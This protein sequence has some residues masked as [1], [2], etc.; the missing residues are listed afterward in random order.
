MYVIFERKFFWAIWGIYMLFS[1]GIPRVTSAMKKYPDS[2]S[3]KI[4]QGFAALGNIGTG[5]WLTIG[6]VLTV[7]LLIADII[8]YKKMEVKL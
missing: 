7:I 4:G 2:F 6:A 3:A 8:L 5:A 1:L